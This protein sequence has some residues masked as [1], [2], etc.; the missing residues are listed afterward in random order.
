VSVTS[1]PPPAGGTAAPAPATHAGEACPLCGAPLHPEQDWCLSCGA[2]ARTRLAAS[3]NW[4][5][6]TAAVGVVVALSL[7]V[8]AAA[9]VALAGGSGNGAAPS[10][11]VVTGAASLAPATANTVPGAT[12]P[13]TTATSPAGTAR[14][15]TSAPSGNGR[16]GARTSTT[17]PRRLTVPV[18]P[19]LKKTR[20]TTVP[21]VKLSPKTREA[22]RKKG[23]EQVHKAGVGKGVPGA[24]TG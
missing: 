4:K 13:G 17:A 18:V 21:P 7:G 10:T 1:P 16:P 5:A 19:R 14:P 6:P 11:A 22:I 20:S 8:L 23:E 3:P 15:G 12:Q 9:L 2:A 24:G